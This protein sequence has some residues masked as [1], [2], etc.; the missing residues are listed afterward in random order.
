MENELNKIL[1]FGLGILIIIIVVVFLSMNKDIIL[2]GDVDQN[3]DQTVPTSTEDTSAGSVNV[4]NNASSIS[5]AQALIKYKGTL[6]QF[7]A[8][9]QVIPN[10]VT[11]KN[12]TFVMIDNCEIIDGTV[13]IDLVYNIKSYSFKIIK[14]SS[15]TL[16]MKWLVDCDQSQNVATVSIEE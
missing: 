2:V 11:Y 9:C 1:Y 15:D 12:N 6:I 16:P 13:K 8:T 4:D 7:D 10:N 5:Y 14:L 3:I